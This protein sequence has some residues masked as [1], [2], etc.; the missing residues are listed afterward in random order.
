MA[1]D[2]NFKVI[3]V[4]SLSGGK[5][6]TALALHMIESGD[7][8]LRF[9]FC[10]TG[11]EA[12]ETYEYLK[13]LDNIIF[14]RTGEHITYLKADFSHKIKEK[15]TRLIYRDDSDP[16]RIRALEATGN[17][18][19]DLAIFKG[20]FPSAMA[21]FCTQELKVKPV[22]EYIDKWLAKGH[23]VRNCSGVRAEESPRRA[24]YESSSFVRKDE[25]T[26]AELWECRPI[27]YW[28]L[29]EVL[30]YIKEQG[31]KL[32]PLYSKGFTRVGCFPCIMCRKGEIKRISEKFPETIDRLRN[33]EYS[34]GKASKRG[35]ST[36]FAKAVYL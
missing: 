17:P 30:D 31:V 9:V 25:K 12:K 16:E 6:S 18:F 1:Q 24:K 22:M 29:D 19:L 20:R 2:L 33:W 32:N 7:H 21:R 35:K 4:V 26:G 36:F 5:D 28:T 13:Y 3:H 27:L 14:M 15:A 11:N 10:D 23:H 34:V 8:N